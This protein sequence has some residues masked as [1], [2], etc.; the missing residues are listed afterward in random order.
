MNATAKDMIFKD[1][2]SV[3]VVGLGNEQG[4]KGSGVTA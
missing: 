3:L 1:S 4:F 2:I